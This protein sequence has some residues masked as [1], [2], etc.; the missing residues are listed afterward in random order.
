M[1]EEEELCEQEQQGIEKKEDHCVSKKKKSNASWALC[2]SM[3]MS[4]IKKEKL[5][6]TFYDK[7]K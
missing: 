6:F 5:S 2:Q 1:K 3:Q 7:N 4:A